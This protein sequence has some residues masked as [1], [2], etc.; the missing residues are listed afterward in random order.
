MR[1]LCI[2]LLYSLSACMIRYDDPNDVRLV[3]LNVGDSPYKEFEEAGRGELIDIEI[4]T[5]FDYT[6][7]VK[8]HTIAVRFYF[9]HEANT[10]VEGLGRFSWLLATTRG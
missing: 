6:I 5:G 9:C 3:G 2:L 8:N 7:L 4:A 10:D 1:S